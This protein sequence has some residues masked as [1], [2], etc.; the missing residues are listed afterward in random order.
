MADDKG[1]QFLF[2]RVIS[3]SHPMHRP[4]SGHMGNTFI[5]NQAK[6]WKLARTQV[7]NSERV[8]IYAACILRK[9]RGINRSAAIKRQ[10]TRRMDL[11]DAGKIAELAEEIVRAEKAGESK[12]AAPEDDDAIT[13]RFHPMLVDGRLRVAVRWATSRSSGG[14]L[15]P[16]DTDSK[17]GRPIINVL[18]DKHPDCRTPDLEKDKLASFEEYLPP[19][20]G[21]PLDCDQEIVQ[22]VRNKFS[23][24]VSP[25]SVD[26]L[27]LKYWLLRYGKHSQVLREELAVWV[28][29]LRNTAPPLAA[30]LALQTCRLVALDKQ[31]GVRPVGIG[32]IWKQVI[33]KWAL[34]VCGEDAKA[35]CSSTNLCAGLEAGIEGNSGEGAG[36]EEVD[37]QLLP[38]GRLAGEF[39]RIN[40]LYGDLDNWMLRKIRCKSVTKVP[41]QYVC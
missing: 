10:I 25:S 29:W 13:R 8:L 37:I 23:D 5:T 38:S 28:E 36:R 15:S 33:A 1:M 14:M 6:E 2:N 24:G 20:D 7:E 39:V 40:R 32:E 30:Y 41:C 4:P 17:K 3:Y 12:G 31:L 35:S 16:A 27:A 19:R 9:E 21:T 22:D 11:W 18:R 34:K 26:R